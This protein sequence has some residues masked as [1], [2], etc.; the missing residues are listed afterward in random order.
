[1]EVPVLE[2]Q[3][4]LHENSALHVHA[5]ALVLGGGEEKLPERH[6]AR[7]EVH[8]PQPRSV[9]LFG[10][11]EFDI[12]CPELDVYDGFAFHQVLVAEERAD[13]GAADFVNVVVGEREGE[14]VE[15]QVLGAE[16]FAQS[17]PYRFDRLRIFCEDAHDN[18]DLGRCPEFAHAK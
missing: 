6:V 9:V 13:G 5:L 1:M 2:V 10:D 17:R 11:F 7:V 18:L 16:L 14:G 4:G 8:R 3:R 12:V 15:V